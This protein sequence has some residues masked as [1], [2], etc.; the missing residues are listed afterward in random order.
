MHV[1]NPKGDARIWRMG[2]QGNTEIELLHSR[3]TNV[4]FC[5]K[6]KDQKLSGTSEYL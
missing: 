2:Q 1:H 5:F 6:L 4:Q 3:V